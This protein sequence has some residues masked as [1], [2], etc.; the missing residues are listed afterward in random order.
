MD[1]T[2][3]KTTFLGDDQ[4]WLG[5]AHGTDSADTVKVTVS[6]GNVTTYGQ[7]LP[8]GTLLNVDGTIDPDGSA[9]S[10]DGFTL[11]PIDISRGA[12]T[13]AAAILRHGQV[14]DAMRVA[15]GFTALTSGQKTSLAA[16]SQIL[17]VG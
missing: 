11:T 15:K 9:K 14:N 1:L 8:S 2:F 10:C 7:T 5:S 17:L 16:S 3:S 6:S 4:R 13:Y 12:G